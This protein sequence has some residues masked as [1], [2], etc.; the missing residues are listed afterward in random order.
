MHL[1]NPI[2]VII[3]LKRLK[4]IKK[5][6]FRHV[7]SF[8]ELS[9]L[10]KIIQVYK[11]KNFSFKGHALQSNDTT[12]TLRGSFN[13]TVTQLCVVSL[14][15]VKTKI[16]HEINHCYS[17]SKK[18]NK[19]KSIAVSLDSTEMERIHGDINVGDIMLEALSLEIPLYPK[20]EGVNFEGL[21]IT[22]NGIKPLDLTPSNPFIV[23]KKL[24]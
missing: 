17:L 24:R 4:R 16:N 8:E 14:S 21:T 20:K 18:E 19:Q 10:S 7:S 2:T 13:A 9:A 23:L 5:I 1:P 11:I 12:V 3:P 15:P 22:E 6:Q